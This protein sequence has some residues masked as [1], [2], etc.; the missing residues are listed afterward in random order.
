MSIYPSPR[1]LTTP[2]VSSASVQVCAFNPAR[3]G[4]LVYNP[5]DAV[6]LWVAPLEI[7]A[8][9]G[10]AGSIAVE[11]RQA[12]QLGPPDAPVWSNGMNAI[13]SVVGANKI[14]ILEFYQ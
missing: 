7:A 10:G 4:L 9:V 8:A 14:T 1:P 2:D 3:I 5:S 6:T 13:A 12:K 11:P